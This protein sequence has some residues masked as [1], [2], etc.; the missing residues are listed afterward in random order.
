MASALCCVPEMQMS[1]TGS[2]GPELAAAK[3]TRNAVG[4][5]AGGGAQG[6]EQRSVLA[7]WL[8]WPRM[9]PNFSPCIPI[10]SEGAFLGAAVPSTGRG[11]PS[12]VPC[13]P[14]TPPAPP[15]GRNRRMLRMRIQCLNA[16]R[17]FRQIIHCGTLITVLALHTRRLHMEERPQK[18]L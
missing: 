18:D 8:R 9:I 16:F 17:S 11:S 15:P 1:A 5:Q 14:S 3:G 12:C 2:A 10:C 13:S 4:P 7:Q 6:L